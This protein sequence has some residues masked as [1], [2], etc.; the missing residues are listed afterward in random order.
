M[1]LFAVILL[2]LLATLIDC[3]LNLGVNVVLN[4]WVWSLIIV[5]ELIINNDRPIPQ[6]MALT[7]LYLLC[8]QT[9]KCVIYQPASSLDCTV[10]FGCVLYSFFKT[11]H[12]VSLIASLIVCLFDVVW[13][14]VVCVCCIQSSL[15][16]FL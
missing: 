15:K 13:V 12:F 8:L 2:G 10:L 3:L 11:S 5:I 16:K 9:R 14:F 1:K 4:L 7:S 6:S